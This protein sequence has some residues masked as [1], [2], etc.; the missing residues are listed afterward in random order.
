MVLKEAPYNTST[1]GPPEKEK[2]KTFGHCHSPFP[3]K[4]ADQTPSHFAL[5]FGTS[6]LRVV[7]SGEASVTMVSLKGERWK[8]KGECLLLAFLVVV[9][10]LIGGLV[11]FNSGETQGFPIFAFY[12]NQ[13]MVQIQLCILGPF[14][15]AEFYLGAF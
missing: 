8:V 6:S 10:S 2:N 1:L 7:E 15:G 14:L 11:V 3:L 4:G 9:G 12:K 13:E 5:R